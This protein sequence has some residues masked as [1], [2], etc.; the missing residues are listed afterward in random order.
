MAKRTGTA[1]FFLEK[2]TTFRT[3]PTS[4]LV[5][6]S[7][8]REKSLVSEIVESNDL[9]CFKINFISAPSFPGTF[10]IVKTILTPM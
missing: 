10:Y 4:F 5:F 6:T 1:F 3:I 7:A 2:N 8:L 9:F